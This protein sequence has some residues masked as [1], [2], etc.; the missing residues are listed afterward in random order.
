VDERL[1]N[2]E[3]QIQKRRTEYERRIDELLKELSTTRAEN[4]EL[5]QARIALLKDQ[6]EQDRLK[7]SR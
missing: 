5:I 3:N 6:M 7:I 2:L 4:R 1:S